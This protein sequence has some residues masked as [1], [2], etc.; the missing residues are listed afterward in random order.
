MTK[1][2]ECLES[3]KKFKGL[4]PY[5]FNQSMG[6]SKFYESIKS[7]YSP[8]IVNKAIKEC[9]RMEFNI[10]EICDTYMHKSE[11]EN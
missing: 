11:E 9:E 5:G 1:Y 10:K 8:N 3:F 2:Q 4:Y 7:K 6:N